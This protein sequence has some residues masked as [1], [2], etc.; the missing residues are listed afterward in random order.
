ME[1]KKYIYVRNEKIEVKKEV[2]KEFNKL[3]CK[4]KYNKRKYLKHT[5]PLKLDKDKS[6]Y[7]E[8]EAIQ[9]IVIEKLNQTLKQL[10]DEEYHLIFE[11]FFN[12]QSERSLAREWDVHPMRIY[13]KKVK[14]LEK[15]RKMMEK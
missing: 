7:L 8:D 12:G 9:K 4:Q 5:V 14:I 13:R 6:T 10:A 1:K 15:L 2:Y 11:L 3:V